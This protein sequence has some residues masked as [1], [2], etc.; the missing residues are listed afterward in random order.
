MQNFQITAS[1]YEL[2]TITCR[3][4]DP[5]YTKFDLCE[6]APNAKKVP[7]L[8]IVI[9]FFKFPITNLQIRIAIGRSGSI[10]LTAINRTWDACAFLR[11]RKTNMALGRLNRFLAPFTN[12]NHSCPYN[13]RMDDMKNCQSE[14]NV[15]CTSGISVLLLLERANLS[16]S[17]SSSSETPYIVREN[18]VTESRRLNP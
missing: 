8:S 16:L 4:H 9:H 2:K 18:C 12:L 7:A 13:R 11:D 1:K 6:L 5:D 3:T 10:P 15:R 17:N 14:T